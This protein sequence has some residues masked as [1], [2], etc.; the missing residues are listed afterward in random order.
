MTSFVT[1]L[2]TPLLRLTPKDS[3]TLRDAFN[4]VQVFGSIGSGKTSGGGRA[5]AGAYL[6]AGMGG[7]VLCAKD[8]EV[9]L[10]KSY[11]QQHGREQDMILFDENEGCNFISYELARKGVDGVSSVTDTIVRIIEAADKAA[12]QGGGREGEQFWKN[13]TRQMLLYSIAAL[14]G[15]NGEV[16]V[17]EIVKFITTMP[18]RPPATAEESAK[19]NKNFAV[20]VLHRFLKS[21]KRPVAPDLAEATRNYFTLQYTALAERTRSSILINVTSA[22]NRFNTGMLRKSFCAD[23]TVVP[24]MTL[25]GKIIIMAFPP[26]SYND[27]GIISQTLFKFLFQRAVEARNSLAPIFRERPV[28][29]YA[30]ESQF[31][32]SEYDDTFLSTCRG[33][34]CATVYLTQSLPTLYA[35]LGKDKSDAVDGFVGKFNSKIFHLNADPRTNQYASSLIGRG[36]QT[37]RTAGESAGRNTT[38]GNNASTTRNSNYSYGSSANTNSSGGSSGGWLFPYAS[39]NVGSSTGASRSMNGGGDR[40]AVAAPAPLRAKIRPSPPARASRWTI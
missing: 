12:G 2:N 5:L 17:T 19:L 7:L 6:R 37:R 33:S 4:A 35:M 39:R 14:Y 13:T 27:E 28:F 29:L 9:E 32:V 30:D 31:F 24:E 18:T 22:L 38:R 34:R 26:L 16:T 11:C 23:T 15:A 1:D 36:L 21:P 8:D 3:F 40:A 20:E 25:A 10:W